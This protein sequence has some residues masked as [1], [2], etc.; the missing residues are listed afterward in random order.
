[1]KTGCT[2]YDPQ[3]VELLY[4]STQQPP[5]LQQAEERH[6]QILDADYSKVDTKKYVK[7]LKYLTVDKKQMLGETLDKFPMVLG[8]GLGQL[9]INLIQNHITQSHSEFRTG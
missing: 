4:L 8:R 9:N 6:N 3:T 2:I 7:T 1:M 5:T